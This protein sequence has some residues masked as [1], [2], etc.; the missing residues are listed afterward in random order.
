MFDKNKLMYYFGLFIFSFS[1]LALCIDRIAWMNLN[2]LEY[3]IKHWYITIP[4]YLLFGFGV[5]LWYKNSDS[6]GFPKHVHS[7]CIMGTPDEVWAECPCG[8][9][10]DIPAERAQ[11]AYDKIYHGWDYT[12]NE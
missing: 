1:F 6:N 8:K 10:I 7:Y 4:A 3:F 9:Q 5:R 2:D 11:E 12:W